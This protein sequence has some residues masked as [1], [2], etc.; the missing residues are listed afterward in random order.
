MYNLL[1]FVAPLILVGKGLLQ[2][3]CRGKVEWDD[4]IPE[5]VRSRRLKWRDE[6][7]TTYKEDFSVPR[8]F[9]PEGFGMVISTQLHHFS[10]ASTTGNGQCL[11]VRV[12]DDK[13]QIHCSLI[14]DHVWNSQQMWSQ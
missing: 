10:D 6:L 4:P 8:C 9:K 7:N 1:G 14:M 3:L 12:V 11:Y 5:N 13:G 2:D